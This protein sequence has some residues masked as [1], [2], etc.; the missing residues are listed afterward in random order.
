MQLKQ[1]TD[2]LAKNE[3]KQHV[4]QARLS[5][6]SLQ[7]AEKQRTYQKDLFQKQAEIDSSRKLIYLVITG[8]ALALLLALTFYRNYK[9]T[10]KTKP[11]HRTSKAGNRREKINYRKFP[12]RKRN[13]A[14]R[15]TPPCKK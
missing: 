1:A 12:D 14:Q 9:N 5:Y 7:Q 4:L 3:I 6:D 11:H 2:S 10:Q 8:L 13:P 15:N